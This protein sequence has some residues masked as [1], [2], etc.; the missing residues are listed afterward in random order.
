MKK[1]LKALLP[2]IL[3]V[4][5]VLVGC[6]EDQTTAKE[7]DP[8]KAEQKEVSNKK[9]DV[10]EPVT[11][12]NGRVLLTEVGQ[13][14]KEEDGTS[15]ELLKIKEINQSVDIA[16]VKVVV[17]NMKVIQLTDI[18]PDNTDYLLQFMNASELPEKLNYIQINYT[19]ENTS[20]KN[21]GWNGISTIVTNTGEQ[22]DA[23]GNDFIWEENGFDS[24][25]YGKTK[26][27]GT[28]GVFTTS[29]VDEL[30]SLKFIISSSYDEDTYE[31]IT[32]EQQAEFGF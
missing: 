10:S 27:E 15:V 7:V 26:H 21:I 3:L 8:S 19:A 4:T 11:D 17:T 1:T 32:S 24:T 28:I 18:H 23:M 9:E 13:K 20:D 5:G 14:V 22:L 31:D 25:F 30:K 6:S 16:P 29:N 2:L 12:E